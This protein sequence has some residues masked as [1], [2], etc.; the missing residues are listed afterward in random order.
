MWNTGR[1]GR[2][3]MCFYTEYKKGK[4]KELKIE[5]EIYG[6]CC[7]GHKDRRTRF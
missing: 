7:K 5:L 6:V 3:K 2:N 4:K 1:G